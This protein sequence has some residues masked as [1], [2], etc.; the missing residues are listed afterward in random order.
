MAIVR[1]FTEEPVTRDTKHT[2]CTGKLRAVETGGE[3]FIQIDTY[4]SAER[5]MPGKISQSLRLS[6]SAV[7][8]IIR[9]AAKHF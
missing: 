3:K 1:K 6:E 4:G 8:Q 7:Q 5:E 9:M 2:E